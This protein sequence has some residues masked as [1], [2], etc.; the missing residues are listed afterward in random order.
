MGVKK[1]YFLFNLKPDKQVADY[2]EWTRRVNGPDAANLKSIVEFHDYLTVQ[3]MR[4]QPIAY[5]FVEEIT[6]SDFDA[7]TAELNNPDRAEAAKAWRDW[8]SDYIVL[9]VDGIQ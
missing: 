5:Q 4:G 2:I 1:A 8:V 9:L 7:Y 6:I 3:S